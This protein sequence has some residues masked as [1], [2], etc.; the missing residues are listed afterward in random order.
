MFRKLKIDSIR[1]NT[2]MLVHW[3]SLEYFLYGINGACFF[4]SSVI[5]NYFDAQIFF[6]F[7]CSWLLTWYQQ[8]MYSFFIDVIVERLQVFQPFHRCTSIYTAHLRL[9]RKKLFIKSEVL[10]LFLHST[11]LQISSHQ[12]QGSLLLFIM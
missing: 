11:A 1:P 6:Q 7:F 10:V 2:E 12:V 3:C 8:L 9:L 5:S 4:T